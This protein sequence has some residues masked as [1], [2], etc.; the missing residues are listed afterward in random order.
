MFYKNVV[1]PVLFLL[2][3]EKVHHLT[4]K[5]LKL[6]NFIPGLPALFRMLYSKPQ[7]SKLEQKLFGLSFKNPVG[8]AAG[9]DKNAEFYKETA[10]FGFS[11]IEIGT[12]TPRPQDGNPKPRLFRLKN[13]QALINRMGFNN[14]G[15]H[16]AVEMLKKRNKNLIIGG[17]IGKNT[18]TD[19]D[20]ANDDYLY[21]FKELHP[22][23]DYFTVN[24]SCPNVCDLQKLQDR[25]SLLELLKS[26]HSE[27]KKH[28]KPKPILLKISPDLS[29]PQIDDTLDI[30]AQTGTH[31][32]VAVNTTTSRNDL[33]CPQKRIEQIG[34]GGLSGKPLKNRSTRIIRY[35][36]EKTEGKLPI[37]AVGGIM[38]VEDAIEKID[39]G[40]SLIQL[41]TGFIYSGPALVRRIN[42]ALLKHL[43]S[44]NS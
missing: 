44:N 41:Y 34:N 38:S 35:I 23:V 10:R 17:N 21:C 6:A 15:V 16:H 31:G 1:R 14:K 2:K 27:N 32:I 33:H 26:L 29:S 24:V 9:F 40:A 11:F 18:A 25:D 8:M 37:V 42:R 7:N 22:Y 4:V 30:I 13:D 36:A 20:K 5:I 3:P 28:N 43:K 12:V 19:N 39:A